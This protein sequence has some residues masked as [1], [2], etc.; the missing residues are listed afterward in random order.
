MLPAVA[1]DYRPPLCNSW[2][3]TGY[4][5]L[6]LSA[7]THGI[8]KQHNSTETA[9]MRIQHDIVRN[10]DSGRRVM[11]VLLDTSAA[12]DTIN[13]DILLLNTLISR[14][15][16]NG[17]AFDWFSSYLTGSSSSNETLIYHDLPQGSVLGPVMFNADICTKRVLVHRFADNV[18][19]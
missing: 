9:L 3:F 15:N 1:G 14:T 19:L 12:F 17:M 5:Q 10:L 11:P 7:R 4:R 8:Y 13:T 2:S 18:Q 6:P 16:I